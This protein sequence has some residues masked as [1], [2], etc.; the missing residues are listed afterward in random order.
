[1][2]PPEY[3]LK[4][5]NDIKNDLV[6]LPNDASTVKYNTQI[7]ADYNKLS[8]INTELINI[9][10]TIETPENSNI[11]VKLYE[12]YKDLYLT[13]YFTNIS[14]LLGICLLIRYIIYYINI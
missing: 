11:S 6:N 3:Y 13:Y 2:N 14:I 5:V 9:I 4:K 1:M 10:D 12:D 8:E 7:N